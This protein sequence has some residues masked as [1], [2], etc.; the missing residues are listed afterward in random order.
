M[1]EFSH[2]ARSGNVEM[3]VLDV[4]RSPSS[5]ELARFLKTKLDSE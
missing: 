3:P 4:S 2:N 5:Q 1:A